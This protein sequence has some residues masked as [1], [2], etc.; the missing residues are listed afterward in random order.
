[1]KSSDYN[2]KFY[3]RI[4]NSYACQG[5]MVKKFCK[6]PWDGRM[7]VCQDI[8]GMAT[9][10]VAAS[11]VDQ[12]RDSDRTGGMSLPSGHTLS[13]FYDHFLE[14]VWA[15]VLDCGKVVDAMHY[16]TMGA[17]CSRSPLSVPGVLTR[18]SAAM[19]KCIGTHVALRTY[20]RCYL[21]A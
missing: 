2:Q 20:M 3:S 19:V 9:K 14:V 21:N 8:C 11:S 6:L 17:G 5:V 4:S 15:S 12:L 18:V 1:M 16:T 13:C 10:C 7:P